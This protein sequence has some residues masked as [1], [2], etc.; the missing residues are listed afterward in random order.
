MLSIEELHR[1]ACENRQDTY[2]D[3]A[4]GYLVLTSQAL[5]KR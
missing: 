3:P 5:L 1:L 4:S 2:I